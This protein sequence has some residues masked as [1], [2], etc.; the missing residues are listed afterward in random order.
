MYNGSLSCARWNAQ[1]LHERKAVGGLHKNHE[2]ISIMNYESTGHFKSKCVKPRPTSKHTRKQWEPQRPWRLFRWDFRQQDA[3]VEC[4]LT[5]ISVKFAAVVKETESG[6]CLD[7]NDS[8]QL[9]NFIC[10]KLGET[11]EASAARLG[12]ALMLQCTEHFQSCPPVAF[13]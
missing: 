11:A 7:D 4:K 12:L 13:S 9:L 1:G 8:M 2:D 5:S 3:T 10:W 6:L